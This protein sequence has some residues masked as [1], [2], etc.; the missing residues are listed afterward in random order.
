MH[1]PSS[2][3]VPRRAPRLSRRSL[4]SHAL[5]AAG[6][7][8]GVWSGVGCVPSGPGQG[9]LD[10]AWGQRGTEP[11]KFNTPRAIAI[12]GDDLLYIVDKTPRIQVFTPEGKLIRHWQPPA[13]AQ[14]RPSGLSF[15]RRGD[16]LVA[17]THYY[18]ILTYERSGKLRDDRTLGGERGHTPGKFHYVTDCL[19]DAAGNFY[20]AEYGD[21]DRIQKFDNKHQFV[22]QW[23]GHGNE[24]GQFLR[25][26]KIDMDAAGLL[27]VTDACNHRVQVFDV[28]G[29]EAK[30]V[31]HWGQPG[32]EPGQLSY[33][34]DLLLDGE[35][36]VYLCEYG[37]H[38]VQRFS[39]TGELLGHWGRNGRGPGELDQPW[40]IARDSHGRMYVLDSYNHRVQRFWL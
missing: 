37:N 30:L 13:T 8:A 21:F 35:G 29:A 16:L 12:D 31:Q 2:V 33:P 24:L 4:L 9:L 5:A 6:L 10:L 20:V 23:G 17:D 26:Q 28:S 18:R 3:R 40:G 25:P 22:T 27:W 7:T 36:G 19:E 11:G 15:D 1:L 14:G 32:G 38:R 39:L 34:Y